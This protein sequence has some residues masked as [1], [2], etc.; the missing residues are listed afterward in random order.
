MGQVTRLSIP[1]ALEA[2]VRAAAEQQQV[3]MTEWL[4]QAVERALGEAP[5]A[6]DPITR[7]ANLD[8]PTADIDEMLAQIDAGR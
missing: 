3:S 5:T 2:R 8:A 4:R 6:T 7:L 1:D